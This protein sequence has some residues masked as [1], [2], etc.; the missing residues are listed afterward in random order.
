MEMQFGKIDFD[1]CDYIVIKHKN[2]LHVV[3]QYGVQD[4]GI[5]LMNHHQ[6]LPNKN[7]FIS[8]LTPVK[9]VDIY[10][11]KIKTGEYQDHLVQFLDKHVFN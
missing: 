8:F 6:H 9:K 3:L 4:Y 10:T 2:G 1:D 5:M 7:P 11:Y